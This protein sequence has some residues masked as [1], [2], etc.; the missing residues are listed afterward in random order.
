MSLNSGDSWKESVVSG[1]WTV[2]GLY[3][4]SAIFG[5]YTSQIPKTFHC[6]G[7]LAFILRKREERR[8]RERERDASYCSESVERCCSCG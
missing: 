3:R 1:S 8:E 6:V 5:S 7:L 4:D 2:R